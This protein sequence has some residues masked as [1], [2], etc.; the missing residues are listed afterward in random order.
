[1]GEFICDNGYTFL[2]KTFVNISVLSSATFKALK[3]FEV[4]K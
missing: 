2:R 1:M 3:Y 4:K